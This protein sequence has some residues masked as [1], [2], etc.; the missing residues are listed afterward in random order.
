MWVRKCYL[1]AESDIQ[2]PIST[3]VCSN[4]EFIPQ[5]QSLEQQQVEHRLR[6]LADRNA[7]KLGLSRRRFLQ[8]SAGMA[9]AM[10][11]YN[12]VFGKIYEVEAVDAIDPA[13]AT[14]RWPKNEFIFDNQTHHIDVESGWFEK[15]ESGK[16]AARF[17]RNFRPGEKTTNAALEAL[18]ETHYV[19][20]L[21][22]DS[23][24]TMAIISGVPTAQWN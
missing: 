14:E 17:L 20:E 15:T 1:D 11:C 22:F 6:D 10:L 3:R 8:T 23:D 9:A 7:K 16:E 19:K 21:F 2:S 4:E 5:S 18:N 12:E 24:T 13:A